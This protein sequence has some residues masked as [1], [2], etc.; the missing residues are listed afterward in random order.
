MKLHPKDSQIDHLSQLA[1]DLAERIP[2][3][4]ALTSVGALH[5]RS[6]HTAAIVELVD[7][8]SHTNPSLW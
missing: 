3:L 8:A 2:S 5:I 4:V 7:G 1:S 6:E